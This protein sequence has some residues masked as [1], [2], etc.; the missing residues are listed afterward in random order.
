MFFAFQQN[1]FDC[2]VVLEIKYFHNF[3][4]ANNLI[5]TNKNYKMRR[6]TGQ[7]YEDV[8]ITNVAAEGKALARVDDMV[9]FVKGVVPGD[10]V[11]IKVV[12]RSK[13]FCEAIPVTFKK[14]S[15]NRAM[16]VCQHFGTCGGC[17]WQNLPYALQLKYKQQQVEDALN[18]IAKVEIPSVSDILPSEQEYYYRNKLEFTFSSQRW[19][20]SEEMDI[21]DN[22][23]Q[24]QGLGFHIPGRFDKVLDINKCHL[25][26]DPSNEIRLETKKFAIENNISFFDLKEQVGFLRNIIIRS[27]LNGELMVILVVGSQER[28]PREL[29]MDHLC[30]KFPQITSMM[31]FINTKRNSDYSDLEAHLYKGKDHIVE[32]MGDLRFKVQAKSF[33]QTNSR[34]AFRLY[35]VAKEFAQLSGDEVVYDLYTGTGT[36]ANFVARQAQKVV[37]IEYI[38]EAIEDAKINS[39]INGIDNT[40]FYAGDMKDILTDSFVESNGRPD[41]I[42]IDP[43][44]AGMHPDVVKTILNAAP[45]RIVYVSCNPATQARDVQLLDTSYKVQKIQPVDMFPQTHHVENVIL[46]ERR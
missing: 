23:K 39:Q 34:Q 35:S 25:Q 24:L 17:V 37:G 10:I 32:E 12:K 9:I 41:V 42:I 18:H 45:R 30:E 21:P 4:V 29:I 22:Q 40:V 11:D 6:R 15:D 3:A 16:P 44:R 28:E 14:Y 38:P 27:S 2:C 1:F 43:P 13:K 33:Y 7:I 46:L 19:L 20:T 8:E 31:Y 36:I 26:A 5:V